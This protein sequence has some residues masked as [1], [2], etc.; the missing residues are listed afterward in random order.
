M[1]NS[2]SS[3]AGARSIRVVMTGLL[4]L[5]MSACGGGGSGNTVVDKA[6]VALFSTASASLSIEAGG[7]GSYTVGGGGAGSKF[8]AYSVASS[9]VKVATAALSGTSLAIKG[10]ASGTATITV[11]DGAGGSLNINVTVP[12]PAGSGTKL[13]LNVPGT[14][15]LAPGSTGRY[16]IVGGTGP[17]TS[18]ASNQQAVTAA[19]EGD[20][21]T[22][23]G[24]NV[25]TATVV[26]FDSVG[27]SAQFSVKVEAA[28][29]AATPLYTSSPSAI[30]MRKGVSAQYLIGGGIAPYT[31]ASGDTRI[32][33]GTISGQTINISAGIAGTAPVNVVDSAGSSVTIAV[34]VIDESGST[35]QIVG[36][37]LVNIPVGPGPS[38]N[39]VGGTGPYTVS[40]SNPSVVS[41]VIGSGPSLGITGVSQGTAQLVI[42]DS[43]GLS[44]KIT[45][46]VLGA[47][48]K[49]PMFSTAPD[50]ITVARGA[51][52]A[53]TVTGGLAPYTATSS[54]VAVASVSLEGDRFTVTGVLDGEAELSIRDA[55]GA[56][57]TI[58]VKVL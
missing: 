3:G 27:G 45:V 47:S 50:S 54:N 40:S 4:V 33:S 28:G 8:V 56:R 39:I 29:N 55:V 52:P 51:T 15:T 41:A 1:K 25:G 11:A 24:T 5:A 21:V 23:T 10:I 20:T 22:A 30:T 7:S 32:A 48:A 43:T 17:Y 19:I 38:Y 58:Q 6:G 2:F 26:V 13:V 36:P 14:V 49:I 16:K 44:Q 12:T 9:D 42:F 31:T 46:A 53:F 57:V 18:S 37:A 34:T 35:F